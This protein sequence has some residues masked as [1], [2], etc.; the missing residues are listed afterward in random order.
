MSDVPDN[1]VTLATRLTEAPPVQGGRP[2]WDACRHEHVV[3]D[4]VL[5]TA[6][7]RDCGAARVD[8]FGV[9]VALARKWSR[10]EREAEQLRKLNAEHQGNERGKWE[11]AVDR[12]CNSHPGHRE[13]VSRKT[14]YME[15]GAAVMYGAGSIDFDNCRTCW[16]LYCRFDNRWRVGRVPE[17]PPG[18]LAPETSAL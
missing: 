17:P 8:L 15:P 3:L 7:C 14:T 4:E 18:P 16:S 9:L 5:R 1:I 6:D 11:R 12:H 10:W 13:M 2:E